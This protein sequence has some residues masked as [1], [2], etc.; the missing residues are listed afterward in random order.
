MVLAAL[1][2]LVLV[3]TAAS[4]ALAV[5]LA[6]V[7]VPTVLAAWHLYG[8]HRLAWIAAMLLLP[9]VGAAMFLDTYAFGTGRL[10]VVSGLVAPGVAW[11]CLYLPSTRTFIAAQ[12]ATKNVDHA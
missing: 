10:P 6:A 7:G 1:L 11:A 12:A 9:M 2:N 8:G 5:T 3:R 4:V